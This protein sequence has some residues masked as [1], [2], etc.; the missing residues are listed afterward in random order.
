MTLVPR[1]SVLVGT[2]RGEGE[3]ILLGITPFRYEE[4]IRFEDLGGDLL[5][6]Q[7][8][9]DP[10]S[11][12]TLHAEAGIWRLSADGRLI[13]SIAQAR[14]NEISVGD[15]RGGELQLTSATTAAAEGVSPVRASVRSYRVDGD[16]LTYEYAMATDDG[17][18]PVRHLSGTL[19]RVGG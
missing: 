16:G 7:R 9:W 6:I 19:H 13:A 5:Y 11:G 15:L 8:A 3:G 14:R 10:E 18:E 12:R 2:W 1:L 4:E 17:S